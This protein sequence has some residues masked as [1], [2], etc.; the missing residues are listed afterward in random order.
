MDPLISAIIGFLTGGLAVWGASRVIPLGMGSE[1]GSGQKVMASAIG[2]RLS[3]GPKIVAIGGGTGLS[4]LLSGLKGF[5]RN[6]T[7]VVTVTDEGGSSGRLRSEWGVLPPGDIRNCIVALAESDSSLQRMLAFRFDRGDLRG[8]SLGNLMLLAITEMYGDFGRAVKELNKLL[9][10]RGQVLPVT[11]ESVALFA[12]LGDRVIRG[13]EEISRHGDQIER[14]WL[15]PRDPEPLP[16]VMEAVDSADLIVLGPGSLFTSVLPNLLVDR[17][18]HRVRLSKAPKV[19]V[20]NIMT[21]PGE[22]D[23]FGFLDHVDWIS[24]V[25]GC[26]PDAVVANSARLPKDALDRYLNQGAVPVYPTEEEEEVLRQR[27][28]PVVKAD[29]VGSDSEKGLLRH[30]PKRLAETLVRL[31]REAK[32]GDLWRT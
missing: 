10:I 3:L 26:L 32:E 18:S 28:C 17:L 14:L 29:L 11:L 9:A 4:T 6:L 19:Y 31:A 20:S 27:G 23:H 12:Q 25:L 21:Q 30:D 15:E 5:T 13:E 7:A 16:E 1:G 8:H 22:T 2:H 24:S